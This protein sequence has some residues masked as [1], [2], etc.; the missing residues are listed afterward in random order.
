MVRKKKDAREKQYKHLTGNEGRVL[1]LVCLQIILRK[2][3]DWLV[4]HKGLDR[5][6]DEVCRGLWDLRIRRF[7]GLNPSA[8]SDG[9]KRVDRGEGR[10]NANL[11]RASEN[12]TVYSSQGET[13][14]TEQ[15]TTEEED[16]EDDDDE[17]GYPIHRKRVGRVKVW[18]REDWDLP[19][20]MDTLA[21]LYLGCLLRREAVRI[22][23]IF[24]WAKDGQLPFLGAVSSPFEG[25]FCT[26]WLASSF[27]NVIYLSVRSS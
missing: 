6:L 5:E 9:K 23:D 17:Y 21:V 18:S 16:D 7:I 22:G 26:G 10:K 25:D 12:E 15:A 14:K 20:A 8:S 24:R 3:I 2:Q 27:A 13:P 1:Y 4:V 19:G 11:S